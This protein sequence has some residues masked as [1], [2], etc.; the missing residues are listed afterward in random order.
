MDCISQPS[1]QLGMSSGQKNVGRNDIAPFPGHKD[2][3]HVI[4]HALSLFTTILETMNWK[5]GPPME[6]IWVLGNLRE[7]PANQ[8]H[9]F[10]DFEV[11]FRLSIAAYQTTPKPSGLKQYFIIISVTFVDLLGLAGWLSLGVSHMI[12]IRSGHLSFNYQF[13]HCL[14]PLL[15]LMKYVKN[16]ISQT[17]FP[18]TGSVGLE[19][20]LEICTLIAL[21]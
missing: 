14:A 10:M 5:W 12:K 18:G 11:V 2:L 8:K 9:P 15:A 20:S 21:F 16:S 17:L 4:L 1:F 6:D 19:Q 3:P 13:I 7:L